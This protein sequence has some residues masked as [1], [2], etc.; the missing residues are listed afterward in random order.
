MNVCLLKYSVFVVEFN[1]VEG[2]AKMI[3]AGPWYFDNKPVIVKPRSTDVSLENDG[4]ATVPIWIKL[5]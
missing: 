3:D 5:P 1:E 4:L 2:K